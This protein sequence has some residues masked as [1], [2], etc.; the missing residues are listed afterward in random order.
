MFVHQVFFKCDA[1]AFHS[2]GQSVGG[3]IQT[4]HSPDQ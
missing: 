2:R 4:E 1:V 3:S